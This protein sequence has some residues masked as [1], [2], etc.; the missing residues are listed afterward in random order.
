MSF[1]TLIYQ[2]MLESI[3]S[4][5]VNRIG[6]IVCLS[7]LSLFVLVAYVYAALHAYIN[8]DTGYYLG[9]VELMQKGLVPYKDFCLGYTPVALYI[10]LAPYCITS[11]FSIIMLFHVLILFADAFLFACCV[12]KV[13][14]KYLCAWLLGLVF[15]ILSYYFECY[16]L[17]LEP[18][19]ILFGESAMLLVLSTQDLT[20]KRRNL[21]L[22]VSG[23]LVSLAF[24]SKQYGIVFAA[25]VGIFV[26]FLSEPW[27]RKIA[28]CFL[29]FLGFCIPIL[30]GISLFMFNGGDLARLR[31]QLGGSGYGAQTLGLY[32][33]GIIRMARLFPWLVFVVVILLKNNNWKN[34]VIW[35]CLFGTWYASLQFY[36]NIWPHYYLYLLPFVLLLSSIIVKELWLDKKRK[37]A[38]LLFYG[39]FFTASAIP[40]QEMYTTTGYFVRGNERGGQMKT[41]EQLNQLKLQ[42]G[43]EKA[44]CYEETVQ[45][46]YLCSFEPADMERYG[47]SFGNETDEVMSERIKDADCFISWKSDFEN[48]KNWE[49]FNELLSDSF[50]LVDDRVPKNMRFFVRKDLIK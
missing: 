36:F 2:E 10:L 16:W 43:I 11:S 44:L 27:K 49:K 26:V 15:I 35:A 6:V 47:F 42:Y 19:S 46:Y 29:L 7:L 5:K 17:Y 32:K 34:G 45:Y 40:L 3:E 48:T 9:S 25:F 41:A 37:F 38:F 1:N 13:T 8:C 14:N 4:K 21:V 20:I 50:V 12:K 23:A 31:R 39:L 33:R 22:I 30:L 28:D 24:L 18:Y